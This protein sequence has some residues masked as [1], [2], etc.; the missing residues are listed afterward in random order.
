MPRQ[1]DGRC[2]FRALAQ[3]AH[4]LKHDGQAL[5]EGMER[6]AADELR[7]QICQQL[8][9][10]KS[11]ME[12]F[13][14]GDYDSYVRQMA[15]PHTWGGE[16]ELAMAVHCVDH[17]IRVYVENQSQQGLHMISEYGAEEHKGKE[18]INLHFVG[19]G[20]YDLLVPGISPPS[21]PRGRL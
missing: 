2:F 1:G 8:R 19:G 18:P 7:G 9:D 16:P 12:F 3:G 13:I 21:Q 10:R 15:K 11:E 17:P 5:D 20:H 4:Q 6:E 14:D